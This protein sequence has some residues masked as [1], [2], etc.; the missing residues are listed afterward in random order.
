MD[1][2]EGKVAVVTGAASG[3]GYAIAMRLHGEGARVV[4]A[5]ISP[6]VRKLAAEL[7]ERWVGVQA[8][9]SDEDDVQ[10][11]IDAAVESFGG[12]DVVC[13]NAGIDGEPA[14]LADTS[15]A[16]YDK[17]AAVNA[18]GVFLVM[19]KAIPK[20]VEGGGGAV[21]NIASIA[22]HV[23]WPMLSPYCGSKAAVVMLTKAAAAEY[24]RQGVRVNCVCPGAIDTPMLRRS[25]EETL[26]GTVAT[27]PL[28]RI[29]EP[30]ELARAVAFLA[31]DE[32]SFI[33]G[34]SISVDGGLTMQ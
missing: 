29:G 7:G 20:L 13:N 21:V 19:S 32:A 25:P 6:D 4:A 12:L 1:R 11:M 2:F 14:L 3:I 8:D 31:S 28:A 9:V 18:R 33:T 15:I 30:D 16:E 34:Q 22:A 10:R 5:D 17:V 24:G 23:A 26:A 27:T